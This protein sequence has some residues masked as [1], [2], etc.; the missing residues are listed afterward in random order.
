M[1]VQGAA[2]CQLPRPEPHAVRFLRHGEN[3]AAVGSDGL[4]EGRQDGYI[5]LDDSAAVREEKDVSM[6]RVSN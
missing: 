1:P 3:I 6:R 2:V 4:S 5:A